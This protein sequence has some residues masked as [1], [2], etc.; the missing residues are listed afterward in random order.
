MSKRHVLLFINSSCELAGL[1]SLVLGLGR[2]P[3][4]ER[5]RGRQQERGGRRGSV[6]GRLQ[7]GA[8]SEP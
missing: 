6:H 7:D 4:I 2:G 8:A 1:A 5:R 3:V